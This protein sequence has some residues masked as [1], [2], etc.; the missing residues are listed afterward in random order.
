M[1]ECTKCHGR[2]Q[3]KRSYNKLVSTEPVQVCTIQ[4]IACLNAECEMKDIVIEEISH[5]LQIEQANN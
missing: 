1:S 5:E 2:L 4:E 3:I